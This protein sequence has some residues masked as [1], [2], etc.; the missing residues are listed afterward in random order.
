[1]MW[2][3]I[4]YGSEQCHGLFLGLWKMSH[5]CLKYSQGFSN[6][7][8]N[9]IPTGEWANMPLLTFFFGQFLAIHHNLS[10]PFLNQSM[11]M[12]QEWRVDCLFRNMQTT[13]PMFLLLT[14]CETRQQVP[15]FYILH[16]YINVWTVWKS[17]NAV[18]TF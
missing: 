10:S 13:H 15:Y 4:Q 8:W 9:I 16:I 14:D 11:H 12:Q 6:F 3:D 17:T 5:L 7:L 18:N 2:D 1:M